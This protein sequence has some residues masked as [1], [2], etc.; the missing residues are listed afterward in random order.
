MMLLKHKTYG[1]AT[2][3]GNRGIVQARRVLPVDEDAARCRPVEQ[4][5]EIEQGRFARS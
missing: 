2:Q 4:A 1:V 5:D 3:P